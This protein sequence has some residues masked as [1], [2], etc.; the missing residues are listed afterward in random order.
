MASAARVAMA[1]DDR[2]ER[3]LRLVANFCSGLSKMGLKTGG[4]GGLGSECR[5]YAEAAGATALLGSTAEVQAE[6]AHWVGV[7]DELCTESRDVDIRLQVLNV[8]L[9]TRSVFAGKGLE[10][11]VADLSIFAAVHGFVT[12]PMYPQLEK[13]PH[14][15]RWIDYIQCQDEAAQVYPHIPVNNKAKFN[16]PKPAVQ[17]PKTTT[18]L[19]PSIDRSSATPKPS[20]E[21]SSASA[22]KPEKSSTV[23]VTV[24][25]EVVVSVTT[26]TP[27]VLPKDKKAPEVQETKPKEK[28][29]KK[30]KA[31]A[32]K[33]ESD[34]S[35]SVL[36]IRVGV[37]KKVWKHPGADAL[38]VEEIDIG[39]P[40][41]RQ[42]VSGLAKF[43]SEEQMMNRK[44]IVLA[45]VKAS[46]VRDVLSAGLVLCASNSDHTQCEPVVPPSDAKIGEK[47]TVEGCDGAPEE[48]LNPKKK[49]FEKIQPDLATD[50]SGIACYQGLPFL[51][52]GKPCTS[53]IVNAIVK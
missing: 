42:I 17:A 53:S 52:S 39:E 38:Y 24:T 49:Q 40:N 21:A 19:P 31:P 27:E 2:H 46:K 16:P 22:V 47:V 23:E 5:A 43:L 44:V 14:L 30:E 32:V 6:V 13:V 48:T 37:I 33:K 11:T 34:T 20:K 26:E 4:R 36:D 50:A 8:H 41:P 7:A 9:E 35:F 28:K 3:A 12:E 1:G 25:K 10:I 51:L 29:E 18:V 45:N 15:L